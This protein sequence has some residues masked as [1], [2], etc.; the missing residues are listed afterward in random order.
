MKNPYPTNEDLYYIRNYVDIGNGMDSSSGGDGNSN[1][2]N[3]NN[4]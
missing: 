1:G 3:S 4:K 2:N